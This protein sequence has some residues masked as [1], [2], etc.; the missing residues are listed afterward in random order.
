MS[1]ITTAP[2]LPDTRT[3]PKHQQGSYTLPDGSV[4]LIYGQRVLGHVRFQPGQPVV[5]GAPP[6]NSEDSM[7]C[8][9]G[10]VDPEG[11]PDAAR[12]KRPNDHIED[13]VTAE[14]RMARRGRTG[15]RVE[16]ARYVISEGER[17]LYGQR[18]WGVV[19]VTDVPWNAGGRA[20]LV[21]RGLEEDGNSALEALVADY[22][23]QAE[24]LDEVPMAFIRL[25]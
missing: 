9:R 12:P 7:C 15:P 13:G 2:V 6:A 18:V 4:R 10:A 22:V 14:P 21:E 17:V 11:R 25:L 24:R 16:L 23:R 20:Y 19:R 8:R 3:S 1:T 5:L